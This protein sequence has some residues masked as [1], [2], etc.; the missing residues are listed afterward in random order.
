MKSKL[1][2]LLIDIRFEITRIVDKLRKGN[3][4]NDRL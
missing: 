1:E 4:Q 2:Q 3:R